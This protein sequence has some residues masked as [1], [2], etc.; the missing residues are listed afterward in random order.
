MTIDGTAAAPAGTPVLVQLPTGHAWADDNSTTPRTLLTDGA[1]RVVLSAPNAIRSTTTT[2][3][4]AVVLASTPTV[5]TPASATYVTTSGGGTLYYTAPGSLTASAAPNFADIVEATAGTNYVFVKRADNTVWE[6]PY[7]GAWK[8]VTGTPGNTVDEIR[9]SESGDFAYFLEDGA[10]YYTP[11]AGSTTLKPAGTTVGPANQ[12]PAPTDILDIAAGTNWV[13]AYQQGDGNLYGW[14]WADSKWYRWTHP[15][16]SSIDAV[17][18]M[19]GT[20]YGEIL[21]GGEM[22][23]TP[24]GYPSDGGGTGGYSLVKAAGLTDIVELAAGYSRTFA[25]TASGEWW[26]W[27]YSNAGGTWTEITGTPGNQVDHVY[28]SD[29]TSYGV[30]LSGGKAYYSGV[31]ATSYQIGTLSNITSIRVGKNAGYTY[32]LTADGSWYSWDYG[33]PDWKPIV[34]TPSPVFTSVGIYNNTNW[35]FAIANALTCTI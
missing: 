32:A 18:E 4:S 5:A 8:Q 11:T 28:V 35:G 13:W 15:D 7:S 29:G 3:G 20:N 30:A 31:A 25:R 14:S 17:Y 34:A 1:G 23:F 2:T 19:V 9:R 26:R 6:W 27:D 33:T 16:V 21:T 10:L 12:L 24:A 22:Y